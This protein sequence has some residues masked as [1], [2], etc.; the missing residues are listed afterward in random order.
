MWKRLNILTLVAGLIGISAAMS[1]VQAA[2]TEQEKA[3]AAA[4]SKARP[5]VRAVTPTQRSTSRPVV[6]QRRVVQ[7][8]RVQVQR[9]TTPKQIVVK[10]TPVV[11]D[12]KVVVKP[13][14]VPKPIVV[15]K[16]EPPKTLVRTLPTTKPVL[17]PVTTVTTKPNGQTGKAIAAGAVA[18]GAAAIVASK[19]GSPP[20]KQV[21]QSKL[22]APFKSKYVQ[23]GLKLQPIGTLKPVKLV[24]NPNYVAGLKGLKSGYKPYWFRHGGFRWYRYYYPLLAGGAWY[25]Y[26]YNY[27]ADEAPVPITSYVEAET[28]DC[29]PD[30]DD[31][32]EAL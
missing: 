14:L 8:Q 20:Q 29:D 24:H 10:R 22:T 23:P 4:Q 11:K 26:W 9:P 7:P 32:G 28:F 31:C 18:A 16:P 12:T 30:D 3:R 17:K 2:P 1:T 27:S 6:Q 21:F 13:K 5:V 25:W 15:R 19:L